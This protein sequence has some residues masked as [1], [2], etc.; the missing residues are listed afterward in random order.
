M[1]HTKGKIH[2]ITRTT[3]AKP[4]KKLARIETD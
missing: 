2:K 4:S 3:A 1:Q